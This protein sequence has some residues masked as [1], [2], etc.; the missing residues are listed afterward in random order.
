MH[1]LE[2]TVETIILNYTMQ[3]L[4]HLS[5]TCVFIHKMA[6]N[7]SLKRKEKK[8]KKEKKDITSKN[9]DVNLL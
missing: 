5:W 3:L 7:Y 6:N 9:R 2:E 8:K 4:L 1:I